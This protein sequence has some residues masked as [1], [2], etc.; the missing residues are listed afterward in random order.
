MKINGCNRP[1]RRWLRSTAPPDRG[2][3]CAFSRPNR[4]DFQQP[5]VDVPLDP[6]VRLDELGLPG[7]SGLVVVEPKVVEEPIQGETA[8][9]GAVTPINGLRPALLVA[10]EPRGI[11]PP[12]SL[13][14]PIVPGIGDA[15]PAEE[16]TADDGKGQPPETDAEPMP[17]PSNDEVVPP[18]AASPVFDVPVTAPPVVAPETAPA[19]IVPIDALPI[20]PV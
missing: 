4:S 6:I 8:V 20:I 12:S 15:V 16:T 7:V 17:P 13:V 18:A 10:V 19:A 2:I 9:L 14:V 3:A 11:T 5:D 1:P